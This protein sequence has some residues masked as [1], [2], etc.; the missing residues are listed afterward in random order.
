MPRQVI[1]T[2]PGY[3]PKVKKHELGIQQR[4]ATYLRKY[5]PHVDFHSDYAAGMMLSI[6]QAR[7]RRSL[8]SGR[9]WA[10]MFIAYPMTHT[11][12][13]GSSVTYHGLFLELKRDGVAIYVTRGPRK[14]QLINS[15][16]IKIEAAVLQRLNKLGY[17]ARFA[18]GFD[19]ATKLIDYYF[20][21]PQNLDLF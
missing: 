16:Q 3:V 2:T 18:V 19:K 12:L 8:E 9:G 4:V 5:Y 17:F 1:K 10:D 14:G 21:R 20:Q 15:E 13:D 11:L 6:N 7:V